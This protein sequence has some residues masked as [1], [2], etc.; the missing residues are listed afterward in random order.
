MIGGST[1]SNTNSGFS[2]TVGSPGTR[3]STT[4]AITNE[5][6]GGI[7]KRSAITDATEIA[8]SKM[9]KS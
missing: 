3:A 2:L 1:K 8:I 7:F 6:A 5:M 4:P 9:M